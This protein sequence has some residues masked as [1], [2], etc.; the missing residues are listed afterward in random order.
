[1]GFGLDMFNKKKLVIGPITLKSPCSVTGPQPVHPGY[2]APLEQR[3][4]QLLN[5]T[6]VVGS[7]QGIP[8]WL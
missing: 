6:E 2:S 3:G 4:S 8:L 1:M 5:E 7:S